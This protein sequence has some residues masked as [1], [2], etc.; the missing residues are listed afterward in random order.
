L[1]A[2]YGQNV[3]FCMPNRTKCI[4]LV[5][6]EGIPGAGACRRQHTGRAQ[7]LLCRARGPEGCP[8]AREVPHQ[9]RL[10]LHGVLAVLPLAP[11]RRVINV[12]EVPGQPVEGGAMHPMGKALGRLVGTK[13]ECW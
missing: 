1:A 8:V 3:L 12:L 11:Q 2:E 5:S 9:T 10:L 4:L 7:R 6:V 13:E